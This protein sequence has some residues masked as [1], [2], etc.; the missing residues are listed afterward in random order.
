MIWEDIN[1]SS[2][3]LIDHLKKKSMTISFAESCTG[4]LLSSAI[5]NNSGA[6][7]V[8][9]KSFITYSN[10]AKID[11]LRIDGNLINDCGAVSKE[12]AY[13]MTSSLIKNHQSDLGIGITGIAGPKGGSKKKP[14]GLVWIGYGNKEKIITQKFI[15]DGNRLNIRLK[16]TLQGLKSLNSFLDNYPYN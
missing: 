16:A 6:S 1:K 8:F 13:A 7:E 11:V 10:E 9:K 4:G 2:K 3:K 15:F 14:V 12:I 5:V